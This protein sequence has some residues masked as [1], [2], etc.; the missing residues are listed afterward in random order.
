MARLN[1]Y[2]Y[3][4][5]KYPYV[6]A[7]TYREFLPLVA[8]LEEL[9]KRAGSGRQTGITVTAPEYWPLPWYLRDYE[10]IGFF[11]RMAE[12]QEPLVVGSDDQEAELE[13]A[14][15]DR[16]TRVNSYPLRPGVSLVLYAR[17]DLVEGGR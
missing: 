16:Y 11:G 17:R 7:H 15:G 9:A 14:L 3:D 6:Y 13:A 10:R 12:T 4:D 8:E 5:D 1:F 2:H